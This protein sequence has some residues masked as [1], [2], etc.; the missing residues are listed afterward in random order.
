MLEVKQLLDIGFD[1]VLEILEPSSPFGEEAKRALKN[2]FFTDIDRLKTE[3]ENLRLLA[4]ALEENGEAYSALARALMR[5]KD[6][7]RSIKRSESAALTDVELFEIKRFLMDAE[8][9]ADAADGFPVIKKLNGISIFRLT[10]ALD[11]VDPDGMRAQTFRLS[12]NCSEELK[13]IRQERKQVDRALREAEAGERDEL[14]IKRS[15]LAA[16]EENEEAR[17]REEMT[18]AFS[19][20]AARAIEL[21]ESIARLDLTLSKAA[22]MLKSG[23]IIPDIVPLG[24]GELVF[25]DMI[26]PRIDAILR[27]TG[28]RF[29]PVSI[30]LSLGSTVITGAN[31]GG[32][33]VAVKTLALNTFL[34][35][36][37][38]PVFAR[39]AT[40]PMTADIHLLSEDAE[41][42]SGGLSS[43]GGEMV[44]FKN[45]LRESEAERGSLVL[46]DEFARGT[47]PSEGSELVRAAVRYFEKRRN[48][49]ALITT[50]FDDVACLAPTH[51]QV[52]G[53]R[54][55]DEAELDAALSNAED[56]AASRRKLLSRFMDY[57][58]FRA[59]RD[60]NP[61]RDA[62]R[63]C[64]ALHIQKDFLDLVEED[65]IH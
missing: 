36:I 39:R 45:I 35:R 10:D 12:D 13:N 14:S 47:N 16:R 48:A 11:I 30:A 58:L 65:R 34:A 1:Y 27:E 3:Y 19:P 64:R 7:R 32:K 51:Y 25:E 26:N 46:L 6:V 18:R 38:M 61:P 8:A 15:L 57:G 56:G 62:L 20:Y 2:A 22:L 23:G 40:V 59:E 33:S 52:M 54:N 17:L 50:H 37:G 4:G 44:A 24:D 63:I 5:F 28:Q 41:D 53:L 9:L 60:M 43:F 42:S 31:M 49:F 29:T 21:T 55:A